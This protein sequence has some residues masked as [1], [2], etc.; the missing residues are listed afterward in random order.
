MP[1]SS[2]GVFRQEER[3]DDEADRVGCQQPADRR[4]RCVQLIG[5]RRRQAFRDHREP[6]Q[7]GQR[8]QH[9]QPSLPENPSGRAEPGRGLAAGRRPLVDPDAHDDRG[10]RERHR[11]QGQ[12][13]GRADRDHE[14]PAARQAEQHHGVVRDPADVLAAQVDLVVG[15]DLAGE[16][17]LRGIGGRA[18]ELD[19]DEQRAQHA[20]RHPRDAHQSDQHR[21]QRRARAQHGPPWVT[22]GEVGKTQSAGER[23]KERQGVDGRGPQRRAGA[24]VDQDGQRDLGQLVTR[25]RDGLGR[26]QHPVL[27]VPQRGTEAWRRV[28]CHLVTTSP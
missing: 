11:V 10:D 14:Q 5:E 19:G 3:A 28:G 9:P 2:G 15:E 25:A 17:V 24:A 8:D 23:G 12:R 27:D 26:P 16:R 22:V 21:L 13:P 18:G 7:P 4:G 6:D 20:E 1:D